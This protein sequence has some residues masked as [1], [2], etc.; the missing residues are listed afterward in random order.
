VLATALLFP[1]LF[2]NLTISLVDKPLDL[3]MLPSLPFTAFFGGRQIK[4]FRGST[5]YRIL[6]PLVCGL[7]SVRP[8][9]LPVMTLA[10]LLSAEVRFPSMTLVLLSLLSPRFHLRQN[11]FVLRLV[12]LCL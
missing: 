11:V 6:S 3:P 2:L 4:S 12:L 5:T 7:S 1:N 10:L 9:Y 8:A